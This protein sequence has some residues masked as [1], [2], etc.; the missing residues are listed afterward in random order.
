MSVKVTCPGCQSE[1]NIMHG[2]KVHCNKC[3]TVFPIENKKDC[4]ACGGIGQI[5]G[6]WEKYYGYHAC[7]KCNGTGKE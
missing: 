3:D 6:K 5:A 4:T 2:C 1:Y 7:Y